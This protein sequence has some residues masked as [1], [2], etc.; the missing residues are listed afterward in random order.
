[1]F[2]ARCI[3]RLV[4]TFKL[5]RS[6]VIFNDFVGLSSVRTCFNGKIDYFV[7]NSDVITPKDDADSFGTLKE[8]LEPSLRAETRASPVTSLLTEDDEECNDDDD[9]D[10][11]DD[12]D[13]EINFVDRKS[14]H[15]Y[16]R[17]MKELNKEKKLKEALELYAH[18]KKDKVYPKKFIYT[19]LIGACGRAGHTKM[20]FK[21]FKQMRDRGMVP[22][23]ATLTGLF[24]ACAESP[25]PKEALEKAHELRQ[26]IIEKS[27][28]P[29]TITYHAMIKAFGKCGDLKTAFII[30]DEMKREGHSLTEETFSF[31]LMSC[32]S[33][34]EAGFTHAVQ[35]FR[36]MKKFKIQ[37]NKYSYNLLLRA[38]RDCGVGPP[39]TATQLLLDWAPLKRSKVKKLMDGKNNLAQI[40]VREES[41][42]SSNIMVQMDAMEREEGIIPVKELRLTELNLLV[43]R[44]PSSD[45][46][47]GLENL[48][49]A[50][51]RL[52]VIGGAEG[53]LSSMVSLGVKPDIKTVSILLDCIPST[54]EAEES[55]LTAIEKYKIK[56]DVDFFNL[57]IKKR[58]FRKDF[59]KA[60][61]V[62][63]MISKYNLKVDIV[64]YGVL[65]LGCVERSEGNKLLADMEAAD[66]QPSVEIIGALAKSAA[67]AKDFRYLL[68]VMNAMKKLEIRP[69]SKLLENLEKARKVADE[70]QIKNARGEYINKQ[71]LHWCK[72]FCLNYKPWLRSVE[73]ELP[74]H[75]WDQYKVKI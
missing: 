16:I 50:E 6:Y 15:Y 42:D 10:E 52:L 29:S 23:P 49:S 71:Q 44:P 22:S 20:A 21:L 35:V 26:R 37:P 48:Q 4:T 73:V 33:D 19:H 5:K 34:R 1:M 17:R 64:T 3:S 12:S 40:E 60:L 27:W 74:Q 8:P 39:E 55:L 11:S 53:V 14:A 62:L 38:V 75:P 18:M 57:L 51:Y 31:L 32:I 30:V 28:L 59:K 68:D 61:E 58:Q 70:L 2:Y 43:P 9:D 63:D 66:I 69:D 25:F 65:A 7:K 13:D 41:R 47:L 67:L 36:K 24:N 45:D 72:I 46:I 56:P 54:S